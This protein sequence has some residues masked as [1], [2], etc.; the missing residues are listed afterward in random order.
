M[1][2]VS[3]ILLVVAIVVLGYLCVMSIMTPIRFQEQREA[4]EKVVIS[5]LIDIRKV[6]VE[7]KNQHGHYTTSIDSL[8]DF[9][10]NGKVPQVFKKGVLNDEQLANGLTEE[11]ALRIVK[12]GN[13]KE[14][15]ANGLQDFRRDTSYVSVF[16]HLF[17]DRRIEEMD[18]LGLI[19]F[20]N[21]QQFELQAVMHNNATTGVSVP[22]FQARASFDSYLHD[23]SHQELVNLKDKTE[24]LM[25]YCGLQVG[26]VEEPNNNA[27]NWE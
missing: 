4:R 5:K 23:L 8:V 24:K 20:S 14:I 25:K 22:L 15:I 7:F 17:A 27:G 10:H 18:T 26:S 12:S 13:Q 3:N 9:V 21:G 16:E 19:P 6:Q 1:K 2:H 11:K